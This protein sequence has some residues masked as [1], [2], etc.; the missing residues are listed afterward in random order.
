M[1]SIMRVGTFT[2]ANGTADSNVLNRDDFGRC[3]SFVLISQDA[4]LTNVCTLECGNAVSATNWATVQS[5]PGTDVT[6]AADKAVPVTAAP[7]PSL[8]IHSAGNEGGARTWEVWGEIR[9]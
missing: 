7:F 8:R 1:A 5:P 6:L 3:E 4:A 9:G 2:I